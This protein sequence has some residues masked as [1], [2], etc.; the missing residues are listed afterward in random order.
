M[1]VIIAKYHL[2]KVF[3]LQLTPSKCN[4][5][6]SNHKKPPFLDFAPWNPK[7]LLSQQTHY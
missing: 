7:D 2:V 1:L 3:N 4:E 5:N 6:F